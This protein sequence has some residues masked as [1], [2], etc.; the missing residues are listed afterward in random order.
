MKSFPGETA[1]RRGVCLEANLL[2]DNEQLVRPK[3][4]SGF[5][6][7]PGRHIIREAPAVR[8]PASFSIRGPSAAI[9]R[10]QSAASE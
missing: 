1:R 8:S 3:S 4:G 7:M 2:F 10:G 9:T 6:R 5:S